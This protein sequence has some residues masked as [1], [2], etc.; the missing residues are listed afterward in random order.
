MAVIPT[1][2]PAQAPDTITNESDKGFQVAQSW[3]DQAATRQETQARTQQIGAQTQQMQA[4]LPALVMKSQADQMAA[5]SQIKQAMLTQKLRQ[6]AAT[7]APAALGEFLDNSNVA[8]LAD[9][10]DPTTG[11]TVPGG[12]DYQGQYDNLS[13]IQAKYSSLSLLP[14]YKPMMDQIEEAKK[15]AYEMAMKHSIAE[16]ALAKAQAVQEAM[17]QRTVYTGGVNLQRT[18]AQ[19]AGQEN[20]AQTRAGATVAA[21]GERAGA[22]TGAANVRQLSQAAMTYDRMAMQPGLPP[23]EKAQ[24]QQLAD[25]YRTQWAA[26]NQQGQQQG[27]A[28]AP[29]SGGTDVDQAINGGYSFRPITAAGQGGAPSKPTQ[30]KPASA[31]AKPAAAPA[32]GQTAVIDGKTYPVLYSASTKSY[33]AQ[34]EDG[35][36]QVGATQEQQ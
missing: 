25:Q 10:T 13:Q 1:F 31:A 16:S 12:P 3:M 23:E 14:E 4:M 21:A 15:Q 19:V 11:E 8:N 32:S 36:V 27:G 18:Q 26:A 24:Y 2:V 28:A 22:A 5:Q 17:T 7:D 34:T 29:A 9:T 6:Q 33:W 35:P 30:G 20:V